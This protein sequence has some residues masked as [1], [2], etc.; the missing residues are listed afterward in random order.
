MVNQFPPPRIPADIAF[1]PA[2]FLLSLHAL[3]VMHRLLSVALLLT[4]FSS[5][6][7]DFPDPQNSE[8]VPGDPLPA[9]EAAAKV[10]LPD[11]FAMNVFASEP[12]VRNP[13]AMAWDTKGRLWIAENYT[14][15]E[16]PIKL[17]TRYRDRI[18]VLEDTDH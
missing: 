15:A 16:R 8:K 12:M 14:Y 7:A 3:P 17:D 6:G 18:L 5:R 11:G 4:L 1:T 2:A 10:Q 9:A 13:I